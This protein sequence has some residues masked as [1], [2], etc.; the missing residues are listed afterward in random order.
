MFIEF[1]DLCPVS[2]KAAWMQEFLMD[3]FAT[4]VQNYY[5]KKVLPVINDPS[6]KV[7]NSDYMLVVIMPEYCNQ[8]EFYA[9]LKD[10]INKDCPC[11]SQFIGSQTIGKD[12]EKIFTNIL[13]QM[14]A[15]AGGDLWRMSFP[16]EISPKTMLVGIDVCHKGS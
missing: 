10:K 14:N 4:S 16:K 12:N 1:A 3:A 2:D 9:F 13:R 6:K 5:N 11:V 8:R 7:T 15:K